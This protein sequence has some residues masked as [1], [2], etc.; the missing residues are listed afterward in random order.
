VALASIIVRPMGRDLYRRLWVAEDSTMSYLLMLKGPNPGERFELDRDKTILGREHPGCHILL[1]VPDDTTA[2]PFVSRK[3]ALIT[4]TTEGKYF[5]EDGDGSGKPSRNRTLVN[6][7]RLP[8]PGRR[9][10]RNDDVITICDFVLLFHDSSDTDPSSINGAISHDSSS[11]YLA[12]PAEQLQR[13]LELTNRLSSTLDLDQLTSHVVDA[14]LALFK[15]ADRAFLI[16]VHEQSGALVS[17][18]RKVRKQDDENPAA[19][20]T[21]L[22]ELCL[23]GVRGILSNDPGKDIE[24][25][26]ILGLALRSVMCAPLWTQDNKAFGV[27]LLDTQNDRKPFTQ[28]DLNLLMGVASQASIALTNARLHREALAQERTNRDLALAREVVTSFL[29]AR[30]PSITGYDFFACYEPAREVGG[31]YYD[32][33]DLAAQRLGILVGDV[34]GKGIPAALVMARFSAEARAS[35]R[36][37]AELAAAVCQLNKVMLP[38]A[39]A[40]RFVSLAALMLEPAT[41][42]LTVVNAGHPSPLVVRGAT[43]AVEPAIARAQSGPLLGVV[44]DYAFT[45]QQL[46]LEPGDRVVVFS[47]GVID[48]MNVDDRAFGL[49]ALRSVLQHRDTA[50]KAIGERILR[51]IA[52]HAAGC[53]QH[54]DLTL[55]CFGRTA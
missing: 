26:S 39:A 32:F 15:Q 40:D 17:R 29:P 44:D 42:T 12:Q 2:K 25:E 23:K 20:S 37:E 27:L 34:A 43:G 28:E 47:D 45:A 55:V 14:L 51:A 8:F 31:D 35:L 53:S 3:H 4:Q 38:L 21:K 36:T 11:I 30:M 16:L 41:D 52:K 6:G 5:I 49:P 48:A 33:I 13:L 24:S 7:E 19:F 18:N 1:K 10:L 46:V 22:V 50:P 9:R 54:D